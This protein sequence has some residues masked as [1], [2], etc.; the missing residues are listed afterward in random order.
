MS[1]PDERTAYAIAAWAR[2]D[3][4][5]SEELLHALC[6]AFAIVATAD[7]ELA[8]PE[9]DGF[10]RILHTKADVFSA[11][12]FARLEGT[13]RDLADASLSDPIE[14]KR[15]ALDH[16]AEVRV[17]REWYELV[18]SAARIAMDADQRIQPAEEAVLTE[19]RGA[20]GLAP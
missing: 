18:Y 20:H 4:A 16:A 1:V 8:R 15:L 7:G 3:D 12:D 2:F 6:G 14:G 11:L 19:I 13:I 17:H 10:L 9:V 5:V